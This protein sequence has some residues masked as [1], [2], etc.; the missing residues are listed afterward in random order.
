MFF[1]QNVLLNDVKKEFM[2]NVG[3]YDNLVIQFDIGKKLVVLYKFVV[4]M[5]LKLVVKVVDVKEVVVFDVQWV[6]V[7]VE[8]IVVYQIF[9]IIDVIKEL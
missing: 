7:E 5:E 3:V 9:I 4:G 6:V 8:F 1:V 2:L